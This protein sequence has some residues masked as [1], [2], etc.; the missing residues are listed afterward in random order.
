MPA[1][2]NPYQHTQVTTATPEKILIMLYDGAIS[3][4]RKAL[5][6]LARG[7]MAGK[8]MFIGKAMDIVSELMSTLNHDIGGEI[9]MRL[10]QLYLYVINEFSRA[11]I[12]NRAQSLDDAV[13]V[14]LILRDAWIEAIEIQKN[15]RAAEH[16][17]GG[18]MLAAG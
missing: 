18:K 16:A 9:S 8:G 12:E 1:P 7:D 11:N 2:F 4:C 13:N 15:E 3:N 14:L 10:E 6:R 5:D 17:A